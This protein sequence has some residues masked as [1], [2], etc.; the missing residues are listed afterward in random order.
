MAGR[1]A[2]RGTPGGECGSAAHV[3]PAQP[4]AG[5]LDDGVRCRRVTGAVRDDVGL[6]ESSSQADFAR[7]MELESG[8]RPTS[9]AGGK[10]RGVQPV[11]R[12]R[13]SSGGP[14]K[15]SIRCA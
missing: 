14:S 5:Q 10:G 13:Y 1:R 3:V 4:R 7:R 2:D 6:V 11:P 15:P 9:L 12:P 8:A